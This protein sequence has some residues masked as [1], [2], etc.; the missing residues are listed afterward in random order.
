[1]NTTKHKRRSA[2]AG[3]V[4]CR[5][6]PHAWV[7]ESGHLMLAESTSADEQHGRRDAEI[8][9]RVA[10]VDGVFPWLRGLPPALRAQLE[11][12]ALYRKAI[13]I[14]PILSGPH[15]LLGARLL[16]QGRALHVLGEHHGVAQQAEHLEQRGGQTE[17]R[18]HPVQ[19]VVPV[20][21]L[22]DFLRIGH[23]LIA[24][25]EQFVQ[26]ADVVAETVDEAR[27]GFAVA[28]LHRAAESG[29]PGFDVQVLDEG[30][31]PVAPGQLGAIAI[32]L[33][34]RRSRTR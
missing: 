10:V 20:K 21:R 7:H 34:S 26:G 12:E 24:F 8:V 29:L 32:R 6:R 22:N 14:E 3:Q 30:G 19:E 28:A 15:A 4:D 18:V 1:M 16:A 31:H 25:L 23:A 11:A 9:R 17:T 2:V 13:E 5:V 33:P 27:R